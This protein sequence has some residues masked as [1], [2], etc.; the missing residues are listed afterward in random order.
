MNSAG[1]QGDEKGLEFPENQFIRQIM[2]SI[3]PPIQH[4][5]KTQYYE[6]FGSTKL[7]ANLLAL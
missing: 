5:I 6:V 4:I 7:T 1:N 3:N 2:V